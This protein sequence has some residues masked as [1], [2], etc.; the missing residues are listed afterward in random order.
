MHHHATRLST[1]ARSRR[2]PELVRTSALQR[3]RLTRNGRRMARRLCMPEGDVYTLYFTTAPAS[4]ETSYHLDNMN[5][6]HRVFS[7]YASM[8]E[9]TYDGVS[10]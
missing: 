4:R 3:V 5:G 6:T 2:P 7:E 10:R 8:P 1:A 9:V